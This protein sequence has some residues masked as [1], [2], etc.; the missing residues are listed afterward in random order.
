[1]TPEYLNRTCPSCGADNAIPEVSSSPKAEF[2][3]LDKVASY[4]SGLFR[5]KLF[6][7]YHRCN[8]CGLL[9]APKYFTPE[10]LSDLYASMAPNM[11]LVSNDA[12][13]ATQESYWAA[14]KAAAPLQGGYLEIG[15]DIGYIVREAAR[16]GSFDHFWLFEPNAAVHDQL[17]A[18]TDGASHTISTAMDDLSEVP[19][20]SVGLA[21]MIHVLDH[22]LDP[23]AM[24]ANVREKL[25]PD[26]LLLIVTHNERS[27]LRKV[28]GTRWP[29]FCLQHPEIY[30][31]ESITKLIR[32]SGYGSVRV[33]RSKNVFPL[34]FMVQQAAY[35]AGV[36]LKNVPLPSIPIGLKLGN[37]ITFA[38]P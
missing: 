37:M 28:M 25:R 10:Q 1:M 16:H 12:L 17:S 35:A 32:K 14:A 31:P 20:G 9:Y 5:E 15:P 24:L 19:D 3:P 7:S 26:G 18:A 22:V 11:E 29:P 4:W 33:E 13:A 6:F 30:S 21:V 38:R 36:Q 34:P 27:L 8:G 23:A 2:E